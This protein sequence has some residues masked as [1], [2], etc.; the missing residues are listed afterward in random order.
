MVVS[1]PFWWVNTAMPF[2]ASYWIING[3][4][5]LTLLVGVFGFAF[6]YN[7]LMY[8][9]NDI[10]DYESDIRNPRKT[11]ID[12]SVMSKRK[13]PALWLWMLLV[14]I[15]TFA[16]LYLQ[17]SLAAN[18]WLTLMLFM[19]FAYSIA[20]LRFKE[21]PVLDSFTSSFHYTSPFIYGSLLA[22]G[23]VQYLPAFIAFY[24]WVMANHAFGAIQD[25]TPDREA[26][27][28]S[29]AAKL[30]ASKTIIGVLAGY[31]IA[32]LLPVIAY[33]WRA[34]LVTLLLSP[35]VFLVAQ[36]IP[37]RHDDQAPIFGRA[38]KQFLYCN[39][40]VGFILTI[41]LLLAFNPIDL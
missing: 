30:G 1:R 27:I 17:G 34:L 11:G 21:I 6:A 32:A 8:G 38:W 39:Y 14:N 22:V 10:F 12:G 2:V 3:N 13:H 31:V 5:N 36:T 29:V 20:G 7:F 9:V 41:A 16:Y 25:I 4:A 26:G 24:I 15:P 35:Y 19:V 37:H 23:H 18:M 40:A 28:G 33:G